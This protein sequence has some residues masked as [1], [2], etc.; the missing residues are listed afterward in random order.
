MVT[1]STTASNNTK[2]V[3]AAAST[4]SSTTATGKRPRIL[5]N[6]KTTG[7]TKRSQA[8]GKGGEKALKGLRHFSMKVCKKVEEKGQTSYNEV[9]DELVQEFLTTQNSNDNNTDKPGQ[10]T[11]Y[12]E[13]NIRRRVYDALNVL[14]AM[15]IISKEKKE[16]K[17]KGLPNNANHDLEMLQKEKERCLNSIKQKRE[18]LQ[19]LLA[20]QV[21]F[22]NLVKRNKDQEQQ[23]NTNEQ[24][25]GDLLHLPFIVVNTSS[26]A[27][28]QCEMN[29]DRTDVMFDFSM[30][31][32]IND[33]IEILKRLGLGKNTK[34][35]LY[36]FLPKDLL[37]YCDSNELLDH[38]L[39]SEEEE[40]E[41]IAAA[42]AAAAASNLDATTTAAMS[43]SSNFDNNYH[44]S[45]VAAAAAAAA[46]VPQAQ[47]HQ[48]PYS[49]LQQQQAVAS[50]SLS[51]SPRYRLSSNPSKDHFASIGSSST[52]TTNNNNTF[53]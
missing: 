1:S 43:A 37:E 10:A 20:Q 18:G 5:S 8:N 51:L 32:E 23:T 49:T 12:D 30:P 39:L 40:Q 28:I 7:T 46:V 29:A 36:S 48:R 42:A 9:A 44:L 14:M 47:Q 11:A 38:V 33:D 19:E 24:Q 27:V 4:S 2:R 3:A 26:N 21:C 6:E 31:F 53:M 50:S 15:D 34:N 35:E 13:K 45:S 25:R 16:I 52:S 41:Q 17:W 22:R